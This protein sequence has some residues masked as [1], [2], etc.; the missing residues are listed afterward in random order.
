MS[1]WICVCDHHFDDHDDA[2]APGYYACGVCPCEEFEEAR[3]F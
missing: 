2:E 3:R 1:P